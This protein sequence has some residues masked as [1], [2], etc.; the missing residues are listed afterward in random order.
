MIPLRHPLSHSALYVSGTLG[1][2]KR[3][4]VDPLHGAGARPLIMN[5]MSYLFSHCVFLRKI[6]VVDF[7]ELNLHEIQASESPLYCMC[8][9]QSLTFLSKVLVKVWKVW[10]KK[11]REKE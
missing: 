5:V 9:Y 8:T 4:E 11:G 2:K 7:T 6:K 1:G 10:K 3:Q